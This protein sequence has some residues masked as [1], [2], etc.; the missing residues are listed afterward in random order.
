MAVFVILNDV[1]E[2]D[3]PTAALTI[4]GT[5]DAIRWGYKSRKR[6]GALFERIENHPSKVEFVGPAGTIL[7]ANVCKCLHRA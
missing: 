2:K 5:R 6:D 7:F 4:A 1:C 3:G